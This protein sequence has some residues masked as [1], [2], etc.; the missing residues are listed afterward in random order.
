MKVVLI[1]HSD[2]L[3][4]AAVVTYRLM[5][6]LRRAGVDARMLTFFKTSE[7]ENVTEACR[8]N[9][10]TALFLAE[11]GCIF[12]SNGFSKKNLFKVSIANT[13]LPLHKHRWVQEADVIVLNWINQGM[14]SLEG[15]R[16]LA[17][18][19]KPIVWTMH[20]MWCMTGIC[21][22]AHECE[23]YKQSCGC[24]PYVYQGAVRADISRIV[25][26]QKKELYN[27]VGLQ[28][29][30]VSNWLAQLGQEST[31]LSKQNV[32][33]IPNAFPIDFYMTYA[34]SP[35]K[36]FNIDY[37]KNLIVM[38]AARLDDPIKGIN[39]AVDA[40]N[41]LADK[42]PDEAKDCV[43]VLFGDIRDKSILERI[44]LPYRHLGRINDPKLL[45]QLYASSKV[46]ISTSLYETLPGTLIEGQAAGCV[47]VTFGKGGQRDIIDHKINGY[48]AEYKS[49]KDIV[50]GI[51]WA[52]KNAPDR[53]MLH[54]E[55]K[56]RFSADVI[57]RRYIDLFTSLLKEKE[58]KKDK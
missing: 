51:R 32:K 53:N 29:V 54:D 52:L 31:L 23:R 7:D 13:G 28:F 27:E 4:G 46:V 24:C 6:A 15:I 57:A 49:Y 30:A 10:R 41:Y 35:V 1:N 2:R 33:V 37:T 17:Q 44:R 42:Y 26:K 25:W 45:R 12:M 47:P 22:H 11:R 14:L 21:H 5:H 43:A 18:L 20:D 48:I 55:V 50:E 36:E 16:R 9:K 19:G 3:G 58:N 56:R 39:Y 8:R 40:F 34:T 38:G